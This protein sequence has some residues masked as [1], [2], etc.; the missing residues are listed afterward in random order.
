MNTKTYKV[1]NVLLNHSNEW[2][3]ILNICDSVDL[4]SKQV[5]RIISGFSTSY[6]Q[7]EHRKDGT[8]VCISATE[9][10]LN[11]LRKSIIREFHDIDDGFIKS[12]ESVLLPYGWV[13]ITDIA[14][15]TGLKPLKISAALSTMDNVVHKTIGSTQVYSKVM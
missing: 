14:Y 6:L 9:S 4:T 13:S 1:W 11:S 7:K 5:V 2:V 15:D 8:Y 10:E 3:H 12:I